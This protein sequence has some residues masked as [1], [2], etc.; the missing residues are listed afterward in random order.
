[1]NKFN[2]IPVTKQPTFY[3]STHEHV[4]TSE[5]TSL[6]GTFQ[7]P[8]PQ[9]PLVPPT[10]LLYLKLIVFLATKEKFKGQYFTLNITAT[11]TTS[12]SF[13]N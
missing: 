7:N 6:N 10:L 12:Q 9:N 13:F 8:S 2:Q 5:T 1:M 3:S 4:G 11:T